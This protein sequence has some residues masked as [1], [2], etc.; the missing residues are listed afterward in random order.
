MVEDACLNSSVSMPSDMLWRGRRMA[1]GGGGSRGGGAPRWPIIAF[2]F[3]EK[4][5]LGVAILYSLALPLHPYRTFV[6]LIS[7]VSFDMR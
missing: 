2:W 3:R 7:M 5:K 4:K 6:V 1:N